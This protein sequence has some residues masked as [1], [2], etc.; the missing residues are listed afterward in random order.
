MK[1][2]HSVR[3]ILQ[4]L[5]YAMYLCKIKDDDT[6][7]SKLNFLSSRISHV[8]FPPSLQTK[9][10]ISLSRALLLYATFACGER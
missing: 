1:I 7:P 4:L 5:R 6:V 3:L 8:L 10:V 2:L 9:I